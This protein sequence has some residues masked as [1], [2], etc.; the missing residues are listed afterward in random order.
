MT[1]KQKY[2][3]VINHLMEARNDLANI[4][5]D[6]ASE[7]IDETEATAFWFELG[8]VLHGNVENN[9]EL[10]GLIRFVEKMED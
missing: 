7:H 5:V 2:Q 4:I 6:G 1:R 8:C 3:Q 9:V 10:N